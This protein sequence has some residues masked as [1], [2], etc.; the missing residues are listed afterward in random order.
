MVAP[1][2]HVLDAGC[3]PGRVGA[4]LHRRGHRVVGVDADA[5]L[6]AAARED[7]PGP[8]WL[9]GDLAEL[10]LP[11]AGIADPFDAVVV[12]GNVM[13]FLAAG[14]ETAVL[15]RIAA[16]LA[17]DGLALV[18]FGTDRGYALADF[19]THLTAAG[20]VLEQRFATWDV[21][22]WREDADFA[23]SVLRLPPPA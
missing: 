6:V 19:D 12:A 14:T 5:Q 2:S 13:T 21:R 1:G 11:A 15:S 8:T 7:H 3:G 16:H 9:V 22:P 4:V 10:D 18:G 20:L 17:A 23:V